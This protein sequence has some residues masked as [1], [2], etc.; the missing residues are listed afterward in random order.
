MYPN[1]ASFEENLTRKYGK[2]IDRMALIQEKNLPENCENGKL[3]EQL[4]FKK[5]I[6]KWIN[7]FNY[8]INLSF[9][10]CAPRHSVNSACLSKNEKDQE[11]Y[12]RRQEHPGFDCVFCKGKNHNNLRNYNIDGI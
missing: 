10:R 3:F 1:A 9:F 4:I 8:Y 5:Y 7:F 12:C 2:R 11:Y 6:F